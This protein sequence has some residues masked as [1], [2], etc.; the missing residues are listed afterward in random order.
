MTPTTEHI[1]AAL[2]NIPNTPEELY[3]EAMTR[4]QS[5]SPQDVEVA[6]RLLGWVV[7]ALRPLDFRELQHALAVSED[8]VSLESEELLNEEFLL[9]LTA[10]LLSVDSKG[11]VRLIHFTLSEYL[12]KTWQASFPVPSY[13]LETNISHDLERPDQEF[14][15]V[16][17]VNASNLIIDQDGDVDVCMSQNQAQSTLVRVE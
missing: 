11:T 4:I 3:A 17:E 13:T 1:L 6:M 14:R 10:G 12:Y 7:F 16:R 5:Q 2:C 9:S 15:M 8:D